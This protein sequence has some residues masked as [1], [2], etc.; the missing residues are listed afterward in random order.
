MHNGHQKY[1]IK[2]AV[3]YLQGLKELIPG[4]LLEIFD[5]SELEV[6]LLIQQED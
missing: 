6:F 5:E 1:R 4:N 3:L 2:T